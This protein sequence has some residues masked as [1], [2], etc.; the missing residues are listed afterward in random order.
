MASGRLNCHNSAPMKISVNS[1]EFRAWHEVGHATVC[2]C[3]GGDLDGIEFLDGDARGFAVAHC[4]E[5]MPDMERSVACGGLAAEFY[6]LKAGYVEYLDLQEISN[7]VFGNAWRDRQDF[8]G[9]IVT[10][11]NDFTREEN[12][13]FMNYATQV[14]APIFKLHF[15]RMQDVVDELLTERKI[16]GVRV[17]ELLQ[18]GIPR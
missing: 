14:V 7:I 1:D 5:I 4:C 8:A 6:L 16:D 9:R 18:L 3:L 11:E 17:K 2:L 13:E 15:S 10:E 12:E